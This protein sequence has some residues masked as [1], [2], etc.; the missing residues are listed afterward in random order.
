MDKGQRQE[1]EE[2]G[3]GNGPR[4]KEEK[5]AR[6]RGKSI[7]AREVGDKGLPVV[8]ERQMWPIGKWWLIKVKWETCVRMRHLILIGHVN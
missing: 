2:E 5:R 4:E 7:C 6:K 3:K 1:I 8:R